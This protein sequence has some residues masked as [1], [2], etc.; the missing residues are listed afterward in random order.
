[1]IPMGSVLAAVVTAAALIAPA[2]PAVADGLPGSIEIPC[3]ADILRQSA[4][5][6]LPTRPARG[7]IWLQHGFARSNANVADLAQTFADAGYLVFAPSLPFLNLSGCTMQNLGDNTAFLNNVAALLS[8]DPTGALGVSLAAAVGPGRDVP[9]IPREFVFVGHSAGA[10]AVEYVADRLRTNAPQVWAGLRGLV[11]LDPVMSFLGDNTDRALGELD[12]TGLPILAVAG[13]PSWCN[14]FGSGTAALQRDLHRP[15]VG[16]RLR[17]GSHTDAEGASS[18]ALGELLCGTPVS[19]NVNALHRLALGWTHD[20]FAG[21][22]TPDY[23]PSAA[24]SVAAVPD[25]QVLYGS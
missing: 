6:Y 18:D 21:T 16:V 1:M 2:A 10:E 7:L 22:T 12:A 11:L 8:G 13:S 17:G 3:A 4:D 9:V 19:A 25:A 5:W 23:Y 15:F 20:F 24:A 14:S